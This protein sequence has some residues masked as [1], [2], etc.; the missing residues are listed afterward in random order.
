MHPKKMLFST[1]NIACEVAYIW[2]VSNRLRL[3]N[4][5]AESHIKEEGK[6]NMYTV[7]LNAQLHS[8]ARLS[9]LDLEG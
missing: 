2:L 8:S 7:W 3:N 1:Q 4:D 6:H 5:S 9:L